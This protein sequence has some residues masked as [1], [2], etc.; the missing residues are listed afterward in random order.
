MTK[1]QVG[2][3]YGEN[4]WP[5]CDQERL[6]LALRRL[7]ALLALTVKDRSHRIDVES[8]FL[9]HMVVYPVQFVAMHMDQ[10]SA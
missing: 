7:F 5:W 1:N 9:A 4:M 8:V 3:A 2:I 6:A 10:F